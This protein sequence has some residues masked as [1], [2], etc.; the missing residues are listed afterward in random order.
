M[1][2]DLTID[3][4]VLRGT[5]EDGAKAR[6]F[7]AVQPPW[8]ELEDYDATEKTAPL[9]RKRSISGAQADTPP[10]DGDVSY[11]ARRINQAIFYMNFDFS[12]GINKLG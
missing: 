3:S 7:V 9:P 6:D 8:K 12:A 5:T 1:N 2:L 10:R 11:S 4:Q